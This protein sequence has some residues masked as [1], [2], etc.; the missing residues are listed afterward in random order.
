MFA[1]LG[2]P[3]RE[4]VGI[5]REGKLLEPAHGGATFDPPASDIDVEVKAPRLSSP[6]QGM[7]LWVLGGSGGEPSVA[8]GSQKPLAQGM[9]PGVWAFD[10]EPRSGA[11]PDGR[12]R[13]EA[14]GSVSLEAVWLV[15]RLAETP[16]FLRPPAPD[17]GD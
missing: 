2:D 3:M 13:I 8:V 6:P 5:A 17:T 14:H 4:A 15:A 11:E 16:A 7:R 1:G 12:V 9:G 10:V